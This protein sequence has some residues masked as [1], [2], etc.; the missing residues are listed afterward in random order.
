MGSTS[1]H[2][3]ESS[4]RLSKS[5]PQLDP[6]IHRYDPLPLSDP[7]ETKE[8]KPESKSKSNPLQ[9]YMEGVTAATFRPDTFIQLA[10]P[11]VGQVQN[12]CP[13]ENLLQMTTIENVA[14]CIH[15]YQDTNSLIPISLIEQVVSLMT[16]KEHVMAL[17]SVISRHKGLWW[18]FYPKCL[19]I[20]ARFHPEL[21]RNQRV[22]LQ[23]SDDMYYQAVH[24]YK[25][26]TGID[27]E[28]SRYLQVSHDKIMREI[29]DVQI[30]QGRV[31]QD[32]QDI[33]QDLQDIKQDVKK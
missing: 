30:S 14:Q 13:I 6:T 19:P 15:C 18:V 20:V 16:T 24:N 9:E 33:K 3:A 8:L 28:L 27:A 31:R 12:L 11:H 1:S 21:L 4:N 32:L 7:D 10:T 17:D 25:C 26:S 22:P 5:K 23:L 29:L 2:L